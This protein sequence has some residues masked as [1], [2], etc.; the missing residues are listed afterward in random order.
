MVDAVG[1]LINRILPNHNISLWKR[2]LNSEAFV[3][4]CSRVTVPT[5]DCDQLDLGAIL[6]E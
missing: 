6:F 3:D 4:G 2:V 1:R 5:A